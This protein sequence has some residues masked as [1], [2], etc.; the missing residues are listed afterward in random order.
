MENLRSA[1]LLCRE[2]SL[3]GQ[4]VLSIGTAV[5]QR[6]ATAWP[7]GGLQAGTVE[8]Y[9]VRFDRPTGQPT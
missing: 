7:N 8:V 6:R 3:P 5:L 4:G 9:H 1:R 2:S